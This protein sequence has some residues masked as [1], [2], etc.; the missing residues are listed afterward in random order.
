[1][2]QNFGN[3]NR[4]LI[5]GN[6]YIKGTE[7][8]DKKR[9]LLN[10][11]SGNI[12][13]N[14]DIGHNTSV[15]GNILVHHDSTLCGDVLIKGNLTLNGTTNIVG[16][17]GA[18]GAIGP[19]G[20]T[21]I[22]G[23]IGATGI[24][25]PIGAT[26]ATGATG[27]QGPI[28][29]TG[30]QG[31]IGA[32]GATGPSGGPT[33][34][35]G[36]TGPAGTTNNYIYKEAFMIPPVFFYDTMLDLGL[37]KGNGCYILMGTIMIQDMDPSPSTYVVVEILRSWNFVSPTFTQTASTTTFLVANNTYPAFNGA[38]HI[39]NII[40]DG[41]DNHFKLQWHSDSGAVPQN[42]VYDLKYL[43]NQST[44]PYP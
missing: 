15:R 8:I 13:Q 27:I 28:G 39:D 12:R 24:Q 21:G 20:A 44:A 23:P 5:G 3:T 33:G 22:Q 30:I 4:N 40:L 17:T 7:I 32:T 38:I 36:A 6:L 29:A 43:Y 42:H 19:T 1:M 11:R 16:A 14:L 26:G 31:P 25:G 34:A 35:T 41:A 18:T 37:N 2:A 10:I 9:N